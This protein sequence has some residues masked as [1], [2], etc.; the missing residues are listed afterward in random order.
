MAAP[1][2]AGAGARARARE[3][4]PRARPAAL[5]SRGPRHPPLPSSAP[6]LRPGRRPQLRAGPGGAGAAP[7]SRAEPCSGGETRSAPPCPPAASSSG[8]RTGAGWGL[9]LGYGCHL[10]APPPCLLS[11]PPSPPPPGAAG[12]E[13]IPGRCCLPSPCAPCLALSRSGPASPL[14]RPAPPLPHV[15]ERT[16]SG[17]EPR[18]PA[19]PRRPAGALAALLGRWSR[20]PAAPAVHESG[21]GAAARATRLPA[22]GDTGT[23]PGGTEGLQ[24]G[25]SM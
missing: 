12:N 19:A 13:R 9:L 23:G 17:A 1:T 14:E 11:C 24:G 5:T 2:P 3:R 22:G 25:V 18:R 7:L 16:G 4:G 8:A 15:G 10:C 6:E 21:V 20:G